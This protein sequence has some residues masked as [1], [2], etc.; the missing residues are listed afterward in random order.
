MD[1]MTFA[2]FAAALFYQSSKKAVKLSCAH[3][4][5]QTTTSGKNQKEYN[6]LLLWVLHTIKVLH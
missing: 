6:K 2:Q 3:H 5:K 1:L 4:R